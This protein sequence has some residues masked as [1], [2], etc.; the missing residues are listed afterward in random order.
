ME[1]KH[2]AM[3]QTEDRFGNT[4]VRFIENPTLQ[5][6]IAIMGTIKTENAILLKNV[7]NDSIVH[8]NTL[9]FHNPALF[10]LSKYNEDVYLIRNKANC[11]ELVDGKLASGG[12]SILVKHNGHIYG[13]YHKDK[14]KQIVTCLGGTMTQKEHDLLIAT[15][16]DEL[17]SVAIRE[18]YEETS[19]KVSIGG[20]I[21][22]VNGLELRPKRQHQLTV[23]Y[24]SPWFGYTV[25]DTHKCYAYHLETRQSAFLEILFDDANFKPADSNYVLEYVDH[26]ETSFVCAARMDY[27]LIGKNMLEE[28]RVIKESRPMIEGFRVTTIALISNYVNLANSEGVKFDESVEIVPDLFPPTV[29]SLVLTS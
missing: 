16:C 10:Q 4:I 19:G 12:A 26:Q 7:R 25:D 6:L 18:V 23:Q 24:K 1:Q 15:E 17:E 3:E 9:F 14:T 28:I 13:I 5:Q 20:Q 27:H 11:P 8:Y 2:F 29:I 21:K 22:E